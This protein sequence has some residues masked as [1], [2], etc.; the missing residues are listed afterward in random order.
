M[1]TGVVGTL[2]GAPSAGVEEESGM[3][4]RRH[5][6]SVKS[7]ERL[8]EALE[9]ATAD[10]ALLKIH[11]DRAPNPLMLGLLPPRY[12]LRTLR[13]I[14]APD[15]E[16]SLMVLTLDLV[17]R[18]LEYLVE[19]LDEGLEVELCWRCVIFLLRAHHTQLVANRALVPTLTRLREVLRP[20]LTQYRDMIGFNVAGLGHLKR[21]L[22]ADKNVYLADV[23][24]DTPSP[25][26]GGAGGQVA[27]STR[28]ASVSKR[29][30]KKR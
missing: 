11:K 20:Q 8:I 15:L 14:K 2:A 3:A 5:M 10:E 19:L 25:V 12:I 4:A 18:M 6:E 26:V 22:E 29:G 24:V 28:S 23:S 17:Q 16:Q 9:L 21:A 27:P 1:M 30:R 13:L 7:G